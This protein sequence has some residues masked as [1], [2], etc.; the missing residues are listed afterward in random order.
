[1]KIRT[2]VAT[3][4]ISIATLTLQCSCSTKQSAINQMERLAYD[5]RD[6]GSYYTVKDW[7]DAVGKFMDIR[8][9]MSRYDYTPAERRRIGELE[10]E[11]AR[12]MKEG[13]KNGAINGIMGVAGELRG[14]LE[15]LGL[16]IT[17]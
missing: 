1:M 15:G 2:L 14:I 7:E 16:G 13:I 12:Y 10:G 8:K 9:K 11:C 5:I 6:N 4:L 17:F 3:L